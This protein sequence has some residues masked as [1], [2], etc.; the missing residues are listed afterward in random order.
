MLL[1]AEQNKQNEIASRIRSAVNA[2]VKANKIAALS[3][4][5]YFRISSVVNPDSYRGGAKFT[6]SEISRINTA[7]NKIRNSI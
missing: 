6:D 2:G 5:S 7:L 3:D 1:T 4:V